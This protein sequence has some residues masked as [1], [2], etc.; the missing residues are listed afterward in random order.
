[1]SASGEE[2]EGFPPFVQICASQNDLF[3]LDG[4]GGV[5][6]YNFSATTWEKLAASRS[7]QGPTRSDHRRIA[8]REAPSRKT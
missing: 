1:M 5:Y 6:Q 2:R 8:D 7:H 4:Q 3:A